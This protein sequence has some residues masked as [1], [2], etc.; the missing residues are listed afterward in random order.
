MVS[1]LFT[2]AAVLKFAHA[3][4]MGAPTAKALEAEE[5]PMSMLVPMGILVG[6]IV[7]LG[8]F[9]GLALV[10]IAK[11]QA[12]LGLTPIDASIFG[13]LPGGGGWSPL[14]LS[15]L[16]LIVTAAFI[17]WMR[18]AHRGIQK[19]GLHFAGATPNDF[20]PEAGGR[21][22]AVNLFESPTAAIRGLLAAKPA[23]AK[24]QH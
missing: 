7:L 10:P 23:K 17:P 5:A 15:L 14:G 24:E 6:A 9:P 18:L 21:V 2:L 1:S 13:P 11:M 12:E 4:F 19:S 16:V 8:F 20:L 3:A 22:G